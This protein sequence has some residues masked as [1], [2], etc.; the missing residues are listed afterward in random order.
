VLACDLDLR[1][2]KSARKAKLGGNA[3]NTMGRI[4]VLH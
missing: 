4:E 3:L 2:G 1:G